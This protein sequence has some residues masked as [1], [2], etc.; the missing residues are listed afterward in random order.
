MPGLYSHTSRATGLTLTAAIYNAD[1]QS[2]IDNQTAQMTDDYSVDTPQMRSTADPGEVGTESRPTTLAGELERLRFAIKEITGEAQW[3]VTPALGTVVSQADAEAGT[4]TA[5]RT[6]TAERVKQAIATLAAGLIFRGAGTTEAST[7]S[8]TQVDLITISGLNIA[9]ATPF[10]VVCSYRKTAGAAAT[11][12][13]GLKLNATTVMSGNTATSSTNQAESGALFLYVGPRVTNYLRGAVGM[14]DA[15]G[16]AWRTAA[17]DADAP[18]AAITAV[19]IRGSTT[20]AA[21]TLG[22]DEVF[23]YTLATS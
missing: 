1:H 18:V 4:S 15:G 23:V 7:T 2:H 6:W 8:P 21:I 10:I 11:A 5:R 14:M 12:L 22:V 17:W 13:I 16:A 9:A 20:D 19:V 3:Y